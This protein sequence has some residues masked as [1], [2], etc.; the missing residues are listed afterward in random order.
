M[1]IY[2]RNTA[3]EYAEKTLTLTD[4]AAHTSHL[5]SPATQDETTTPNTNKHTKPQPEAYSRTKGDLRSPTLI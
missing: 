3:P 1:K 2:R 5:P 4:D